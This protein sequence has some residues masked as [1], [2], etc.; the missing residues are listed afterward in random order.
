MMK[1]NRK[2]EMNTITASEK[3]YTNV[4]DKSLRRPLSVWLLIVLQIFLAMGAFL[5]GGAF[6]LA[7]DGHLIQMP[8]SHLKN[9]PFSSFLIPG[10]L[11]FTFLGVYP[12]AVTYGLWKRP[13]WRWPDIINPFKRMHW[14]WA[15]S[16]AAGVIV[17]IWIT[18]ETLWVPFGIVHIVYLVY[19]LVILGVTLLPGVHRYY[20]RSPE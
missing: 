1:K 17:L 10:I 12:V 13:T 5:G 15:G 16:L 2:H 18:V 14:S 19:G 11:L 6:I 7:P 3:E 8:F 4:E 9:S 20:T